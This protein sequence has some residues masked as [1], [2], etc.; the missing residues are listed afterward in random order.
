MWHVVKYFDSQVSLLIPECGL[1]PAEIANVINNFSSYYLVRDLPVYRFL[2]EDMLKIMKKGKG[3][4]CVLLPHCSLFVSFLFCPE[5]FSIVS[6]Q[7]VSMHSLT[8]PDLMK[9]MLLL[10]WAVRIRLETCL[11]IV[12][13]VLIKNSKWCFAYD[14]PECQ[15]KLLT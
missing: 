2:E 14:L 12:L 1:L 5:W 10:L 4:D 9:T 3:K 6:S 15:L 7:A 13:K 8:K 11:Q